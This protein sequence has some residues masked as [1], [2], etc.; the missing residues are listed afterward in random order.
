MSPYRTA[1]KLGTHDLDDLFRAKEVLQR[2]AD[3]INDVSEW[4]AAGRSTVVAG[5]ETLLKEPLLHYETPTSR[6]PQR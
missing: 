2:H 6:M 1:H 3:A 5:I 4:C